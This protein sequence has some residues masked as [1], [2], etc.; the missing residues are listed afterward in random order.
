MSAM[1]LDGLLSKFRVNRPLTRQEMAD[2]LLP[3]KSCG[4]E[5]QNLL[6]TIR[7]NSTFLEMRDKFLL[8]KGLWTFW[9][10]FIF[11]VFG[12]LLI[13]MTVIAFFH[14]PTLPDAKRQELVL[15]LSLIYAMFIPLILF[16]WQFRFRKESF[17]YTHYP[18]RFNRRTRRVHVFRLDGTVMTEAWEKLFFTLCQNKYG[19]DDW[20]VRAHRLAADGRTVLETFALGYRS[21]RA[22][23]NLLGQW[24]FIRR[25]MEEGPESVLPLIDHVLDIADRRETWW[26]GVRML[27]ASIGN[28]ILM[29]PL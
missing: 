8:V 29:F 10:L 15:S 9:S 23:V 21:G 27:M 6:G 13:S 4:A 22:S 12:G 7:M 19:G 26:N 5:P 18:I 24:E 16:F 20:E 11:V 2:R 14:W 1:A 25:Y 28:D 17:R 3:G